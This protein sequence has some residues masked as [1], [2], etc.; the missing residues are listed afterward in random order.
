MAVGDL[1]LIS[2]PG[3]GIPNGTEGP[4]LHAATRVDVPQ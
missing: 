1:G 2:G 4:S 3:T